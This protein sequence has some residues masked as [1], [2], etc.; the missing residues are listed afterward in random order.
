MQINKVIIS[1]KCILFTDICGAF[2]NRFFGDIECHFDI[3]QRQH[4]RVIT[5][6][7]RQWNGH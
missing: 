2:I 6:F 7:N 5:W 1:N 3:R 4:G